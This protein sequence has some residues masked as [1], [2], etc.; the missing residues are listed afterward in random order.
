VPATRSRRSAAV[1]DLDLPSAQPVYFGLLGGASSP[2]MQDALNHLKHQVRDGLG[3]VGVRLL[4]R[5]DWRERI[6][7]AGAALFLTPT[8]G[9]VARLWHLI[10]RGEDDSL[11]LVFVAR[12]LD[13]DFV[14]HGERLLAKLW[15]VRKR[16]TQPVDEKAILASAALGVCVA[17][18]AALPDGPV[19][20]R[21]AAMLPAGVVPAVRE[22]FFDR[23]EV[24][25]A[26]LR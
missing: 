14:R 4:F 1:V 21:H 7:G 10:A 2:E 11:F 12:Q 8:S 20:G 18:V 6:A 17:L 22:R 26:A 9:M 19:Q 3:R 23:A 25:L 24:A 5:G 15:R 16:P 13:P